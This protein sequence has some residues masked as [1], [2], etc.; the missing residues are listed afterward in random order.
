MTPIIDH[1]SP[2]SRS[3]SPRCELSCGIVR[4]ARADRDPVAVATDLEHR[5]RDIAEVPARRERARR[6]VN[7]PGEA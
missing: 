5:H 7:G 3:R 2:R 1:A 6:G 4:F